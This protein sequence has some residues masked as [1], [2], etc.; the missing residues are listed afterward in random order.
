MVRQSKDIRILKINRK[1]N[2]SYSKLLFEHIKYF[3]NI[4]FLDFNNRLSGFSTLVD[5]EE[6]LKIKEDP[7]KENQ[8]INDINNWKFDYPFIHKD[9]Y[10]LKGILRKQVLE[11]MNELGLKVIP[12]VS[13]DLICEG[14]IDY[15]TIV[16]Q[17]NNE[18][19][20]IHN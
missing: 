8:F 7:S 11:K 9:Y 3:N 16:T 17:I 1:E 18:I 20:N 2:H 6:M 13:A 5:I 15:E 19:H 12:V 14:I 10:I 4:I